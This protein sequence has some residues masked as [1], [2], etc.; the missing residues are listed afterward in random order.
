VGC[1]DKEK[2]LAAEGGACESI[3]DCQAGLSCVA[4]GVDSRVCRA[5]SVEAPPADATIAIDATPID[6]APDA[7]PELDSGADVN[8]VDADAATDASDAAPRDASDA[9]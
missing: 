2:V 8:E 6:A 3:L 7:T 9:G 1:E 4:T 5:V